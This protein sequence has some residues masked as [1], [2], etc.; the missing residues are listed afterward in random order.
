MIKFVKDEETRL[1]FVS[2]P[3]TKLISYSLLLIVF[4]PLAYWTVFVTPVSSSLVCQR[5]NLTQIDCL[6]QEKSLLNFPLLNLEINNLKKLNRYIFGLSNGKQITLIA[7]AD[8]PN[9][10]LISSR[11]KYKYPS[12]SFTLLTMNPKFGFQL[13]NQRKQLTEFIKEKQQ[14]SIK[15][16][17]QLGWFAIFL[18]PVFIMPLGLIRLIFTFPFKTTYEFD[19]TNRKLTISARRILG[20]EERKY[21]FDRIKQVAIDTKD[22]DL[23]GRLM[24]QF[25]PEYNYPIEEYIDAEYGEANYQKINRFI[26]QYK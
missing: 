21:S 24:L 14:Q 25:I 12:K 5:N 9:F 1:K 17:V 11:K 20:V 23:G 7:D 4:L 26:E 3:Y 6:L 2:S 8:T 15:F 18:T 22:L 13:F 10:Q 16:K 19:G